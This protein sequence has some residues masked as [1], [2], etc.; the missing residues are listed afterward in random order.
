MQCTHVFPLCLLSQIPGLLQSLPLKLNFAL[1]VRPLAGRG[2]PGSRR[3]V[4]ARRGAGARAREQPWR[5]PV[6][7]CGERRG[8]WGA[9]ARGGGGGGFGRE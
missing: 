6:T 1:E 2:A 9:L 8:A 7:G 4:S 5:R 3:R